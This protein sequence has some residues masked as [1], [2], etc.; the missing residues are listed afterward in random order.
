V[1]LLIT[2]N[3]GALPRFGGDKKKVSEVFFFANFLKNS[4][5]LKLNYEISK[6]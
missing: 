5:N 2:N 1:V 4:N 6:V 3:V